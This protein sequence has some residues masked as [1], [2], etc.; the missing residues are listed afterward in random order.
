MQVRVEEREPS[1]FVI[2]LDGELDMAT[3]PLLAEAATEL[4]ACGGVASLVIDLA[5]LQFLD[6]SGM[7]A[8]LRV[9]AA[10]EET[11][12]TLRVS[13]P[14]QHV[15][16]VLRIAALDHLLGVDDTGPPGGGRGERI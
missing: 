8:L 11:G 7:R 1:E 3:E 12:A 9:H 15:A 4:L 6:S 13:R 14:Q 5:R 10:A 16:Y 2:V